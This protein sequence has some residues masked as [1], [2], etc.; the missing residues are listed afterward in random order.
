MRTNR[1]LPLIGVL[2]LGV[3]LAHALPAEAAKVTQRTTYF[4][5]KGSTL[6]ELDR[7][8]SRS[9][10]YVAETGLRHPGATEVKFDGQVT[11]KRD[12]SGCQVDQTNLSLTLNMTLPRWTPP[13]R[14]AP[15]T[16][17]VW[18]TLEEDIRRHENRH[19]DIAKEWLKRM[20]MA[21][22]N[23]RTQPSC[24]AMEADVNNITQRYLA[25]H[26]RAQIEFDTIEGREVNFRLRR[27]L[28]R[29]M[30]EYVR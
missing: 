24:A 23:L 17:M 21:I 5:V 11:Y 18:R 13:K 20:E 15:E 16:V 9:G 27:A 28:S 19:A 12:A 26:E 7:D 29:T 30:Q 1:G 4:A 3:G 25:S 22:R 14:V 10:P 8:L 6:E 2:A